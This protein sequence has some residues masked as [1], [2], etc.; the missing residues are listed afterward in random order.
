[1]KAVRVNE[2]GNVYLVSHLEAKFMMMKMFFP[3]V[4]KPTKQEVSMGSGESLSWMYG[5][6]I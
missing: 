4:R 6:E 1:M 5:S 3:E 2:N